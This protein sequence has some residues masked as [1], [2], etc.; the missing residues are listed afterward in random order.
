M[1][2]WFLVIFFLAGCS[3]AIPM[4]HEEYA[5]AYGWQIESLEGQE[6]VVIQKEAD[7]QG[8]STSFFDTA[9]YEGREAQVTTY[10]LKEKQVSGDD[11]FLSIYVIDNN[12][13]GA[14][15][16]LANWSP[17]SFDPKKKDELTGEGIIEHE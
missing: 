9:P 11:L 6:T 1:K 12:I 13:I 17:G 4:E 8:I 16:S 3:P 14:S 10:K 5:E 15:G 7:T 2:N